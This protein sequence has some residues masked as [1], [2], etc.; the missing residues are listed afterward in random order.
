MRGRRHRATPLRRNESAGCP[1]SAA[2]YSPSRWMVRLAWPSRG[3]AC[4]PPVARGRL[5]ALLTVD[6]ARS[7]LPRVQVTRGTLI[8]CDC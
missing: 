1:G 5:T 6:V 7:S 8:A 4:E 2:L 3:R